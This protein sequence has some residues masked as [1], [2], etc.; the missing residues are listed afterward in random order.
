MV[1]E[2]QPEEQ[3]PGAPTESD[4]AKAADPFKAD[5]FFATPE[6]GFAQEEHSGQPR[7]HGGDKPRRG[8]PGR[9]GDPRTVGGRTNRR[10]DTHTKD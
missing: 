9:A 5:S 2:E 7:E 4:V 6:A 3:L 10:A 8:D 1:F